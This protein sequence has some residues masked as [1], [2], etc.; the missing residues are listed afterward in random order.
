VTRRVLALVGFMMLV[1][2]FHAV[3]VQAQQFGYWRSQNQ[4]CVS[5]DTS[6][7][8]NDWKD[9]GPEDTSNQNS[10]RVAGGMCNRKNHCV[11]P[12]VDNKTRLDNQWM[13]FCSKEGKMIP[14]FR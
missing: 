6:G 1:V 2:Q 13:V 5:W 8:C 14:A 3:P 9:T 4:V 7:A 12:V 10:P 11:T